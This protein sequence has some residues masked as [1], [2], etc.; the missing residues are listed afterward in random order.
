MK[1]N[2]KTELKTLWGKPLNDVEGNTYT[3]AEAIANVLLTDE[4]GGKMKLYVLAE[5]FAK[6]AELDLDAADLA[7]VRGALERTTKYT[8][9]VAGQCLLLLESNT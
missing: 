5:R 2:T 7:L 8:P 3:L 1:I 9:L 6:E 4:S